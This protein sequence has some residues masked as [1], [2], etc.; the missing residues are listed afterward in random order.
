MFDILHVFCNGPITLL[1]TYKIMVM[2]H[3]P[4]VGGRGICLLEGGPH[5]LRCGGG[6]EKLYECG[7]DGFDNCIKKKLIL[8]EPKRIIRIWGGRM[9]RPYP[10]LG[11]E[12]GPSMGLGL[13]N[14]LS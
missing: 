7:R 4:S 3:D 8:S 14:L 12:R 6:G 5:S 9:S 1:R 11:E 13:F 10:R 2:D